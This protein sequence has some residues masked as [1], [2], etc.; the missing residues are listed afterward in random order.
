MIALFSI[1]HHQFEH[2][3]VLQKNAQFQQTT[4]KTDVFVGSIDD[5]VFGFWMVSLGITV[6][7]IA[8]NAFNVRVWVVSMLQQ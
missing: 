6:W 3:K 2:G 1:V 4:E 7:I 5:F 8:S